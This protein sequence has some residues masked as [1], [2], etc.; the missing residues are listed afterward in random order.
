MHSAD[1]AHAVTDLTLASGGRWW[2]SRIKRRNWRRF[3]QAIVTSTRPTAASSTSGAADNVWVAWSRYV[4]IASTPPSQGLR[5]LDAVASVRLWDHMPVPTW[6]PMPRPLEGAL[7]WVAASMASS[8]QYRRDG[9]DA[10]VRGSL[11]PHAGTRAI[12]E[13]SRRSAHQACSE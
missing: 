6:A 9:V 7:G 3:Q 11:K 5:E 10:A 12:G 2:S 13:A 4:P 1:V 8:S